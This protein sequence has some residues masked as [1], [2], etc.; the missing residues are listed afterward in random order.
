MYH[1]QAMIATAGRILRQLSHDHRTLAL[2]FV[3]PC[4]LLG[5]L[6][7]LFDQNI[8]LF[9]TFAPVLLGV[10]P[11]IIMFIVTS[12][13]TVRERISGTMER[14]MATPVGKLDF[15]AG[16][17]IAFGVLAIIQALLASTVLLYFIGIDIQGPDWFL[18]L[19]ALADALL[20]TALGLFV[21]AF[22]RSEFQAVQF[23]PAFVLPQLLICGLFVPLTQ[24]PDLLESIAYCLPLTYAV[25]ALTQIATNTVVTS[26]AWRDIWLVL[27][28]ALSALLLGAVTLRR[29]GA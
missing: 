1:L 21:S 20:G 25:D 11:F 3:V 17:M 23:M 5:L 6:R 10:F 19:M 16:Y 8:S 26:D 29:K 15:L 14:L 7:W 27:G 24:M 9:D 22:A 13:T 12:I 28:F 4:V 18:I 2:I